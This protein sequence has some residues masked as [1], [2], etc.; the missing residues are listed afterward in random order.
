MVDNGLSL[1][2]G[3]T[4]CILVGSQRRLSEAE[5][6]RVLCDGLE[7]KR[8]SSVRFLGV[9][10]DENFKGKVQEMFVMKKVAGFFVSKCPSFGL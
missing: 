7:V 6:F 3:K 9:M 10:L 5:G 1:H 8:V 4:E 2:L